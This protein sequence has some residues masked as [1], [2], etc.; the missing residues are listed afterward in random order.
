MNKGLVVL[1]ALLAL[2]SS[3]KYKDTW[4]TKTF[5]K[6]FS[7]EVPSFMKEEQ[8]KEGAPFQYANRFRNLY[9]VVFSEK[10]DSVAGDFA[11]YCGANA[12][13][14]KKALGNPLTSDSSDVTIGGYKGVKQEI[15][16]IMGG[17]VKEKIFYTHITLD[18][19][20]GRYYQICSWTRGEDRKLKYKDVLDRITYSFTPVAK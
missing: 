11:Q 8:L 2:L 18:A 6:E 17:E 20:N 4:E 13:R 15:F 5:N 14:L 19:P 1:V 9:V 3:C 10:K 12:L 7:M 16:G